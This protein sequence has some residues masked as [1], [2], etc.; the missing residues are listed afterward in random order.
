MHFHWCSLSTR[1]ISLSLSALGNKW[2]SDTADLDPQIEVNTLMNCYCYWSEMAVGK[3]W[4][5]EIEMVD[6]DRAGKRR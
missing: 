4:V 6:A 2:T 5:T 3:R 1:A